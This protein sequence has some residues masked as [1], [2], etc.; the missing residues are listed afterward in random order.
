MENPNESIHRKKG[1]FP[2]PPQL[3]SFLSAPNPLIEVDEHLQLRPLKLEQVPILFQLI[4]DN[5]TYLQ[6]WLPWIEKIQKESD[7][8]QFIRGVRYRNV[9]SGRWVYGIWYQDEMVGLLDF[10]EGKRAMSQVSLGY[11]IAEKF[12][13]KGIITRSVSACLDYLFTQKG[14]E[15]VLIKCA[16]NNLKSQA[17]PNRLNF[18]WDGMEFEAGTLQ[19]EEVDI[20]V[21]AMHGRD[22]LS[23][24]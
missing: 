23:Q 8:K 7:T 18:R 24:G 16:N 11:W 2:S 20:L 15:K 14:L 13:G 22:W 12:Q 5:R 19:G 6:E 4:E 17:V 9:Y 10:N 21:F 1:L 3:P